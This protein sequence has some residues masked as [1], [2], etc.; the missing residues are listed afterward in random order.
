MANRPTNGWRRLPATALLAFAL[1]PALTVVTLP[2]PSFA[3]DDDVD[4]AARKADW[5]NH[6]R[7]IRTDAV[8]TRDNATRLRRAFDLSQHSN[9]PRSSVRR[10]YE[11]QVIETGQKAD[12]LEAALA[13]FLAE[14]REEQI[15]RA[16]IDEVDEEPVNLI[17]PAAAASAA[18]GYGF[19]PASQPDAATRRDSD[20]SRDQDDDDETDEEPT[21]SRGAEYD[22]LSDDSNDQY[23][24][25]DLD[26]T[27]DTTA[28]ESKRDF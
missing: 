9:D 11:R 6:Y 24:A 18:F 2:T 28:E 17:S 27:D 14:A 10:R 22:D 13:K 16:W 23:R 4:E 15:P 12:E 26:D 1:A 3:A 21:D 19:D 8:R 5:Q 7:T 25:I 20:R